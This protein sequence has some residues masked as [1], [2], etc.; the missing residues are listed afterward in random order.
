MN[1]RSFMPAKAPPLKCM[2]ARQAPVRTGLP[3]LV[4]GTGLSVQ[5]LATRGS[6]SRVTSQVSG[7]FMLGRLLNSGMRGYGSCHGSSGL[8]QSL[9][10]VL[11]L[12]PVEGLR[13]HLTHRARVQATRVDAVTVGKGARDVEGLDATDL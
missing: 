8:R 13:H 11:P 12:L 6:A 7:I 3:P 5:A 4:A 1:S 9:D 10:I 2:C